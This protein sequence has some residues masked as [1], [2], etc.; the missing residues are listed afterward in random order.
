MKSTL[1]RLA[2][3]GLVAIG[4]SVQGDIYVPSPVEGAYPPVL[5]G[6]LPTPVGE[7]LLV[8]WG[9]TALA[10]GTVTV[11]IGYEWAEVQA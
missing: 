5:K 9:P 6:Q 4:T 10:T 7:G 1:L 8:Q 11:G 3:I 2:A